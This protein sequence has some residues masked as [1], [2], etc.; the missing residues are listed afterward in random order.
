MNGCIPQQMCWMIVILIPKGGGDYQGIG[1]LEPFW[2]SIE[3]FIDN[4]L[5]VIDFHDN[6]HSFMK[7]RGCGTAMM[8]AKLAQQFAYLEQQAFYGVFVD[9]KKAY[10]AMDRERCIELLKRYGVGPRILVMITFFWDHAMMA[11][12]ANRNYGEPFQGF[13]GVT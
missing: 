2:K 3:I 11:C 1:L 4:R 9:F 7:G 6:L 8:E 12:Q 5:K 13:R 10:D